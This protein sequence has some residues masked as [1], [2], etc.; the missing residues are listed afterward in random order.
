MACTILVMPVA[1]HLALFFVPVCR[2]M[3]LGIMAFLDQML[4]AVACVRL[5]LLVFMHFALSVLTVLVSGD[6]TD[7]VPGQGV[8]AL[9]CATTGAGFCPDI[10][11]VAQRQFPMVQLFMLM[12]QLSDKVV[13]V[14]VVVQRQVPQFCSCSSFTVVDT[15]V[16]A[17][18]L[19]PMVP[20]IEISQ[21]QFDKVVFVPVVQVCS[22]IL[23]VASCRRHP[24]RGAK[25]GSHGLAR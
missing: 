5:V 15:P 6:S 11:V 8:L 20:A 10:P 13:E 3:L 21:S 12:V 22:S 14:P 25:A 18:W 24:C 4:V 17:Q 19:I 16:F 9:R 2:L 1:M 7:A 23:Q